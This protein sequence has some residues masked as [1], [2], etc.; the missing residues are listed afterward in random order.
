MKCVLVCLMVLVASTAKAAEPP[1][2]LLPELRNGGY[3][4]FI[5]HPKTNSDQA[6]TDPLHLDN[7]KAQR[8]LSDEGRA[9]AKALGESLRTLKI[10]VGTIIASKFN[11]AQ[12]AAKLLDVGEVT[13]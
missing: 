6:D 11:R 3:V 2:N 13:A 7:V 8:Q 12:E 1:A 4:L 5:R 9:Q 10:P